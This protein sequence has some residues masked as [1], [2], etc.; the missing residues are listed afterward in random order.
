MLVPELPQSTTPS[1][2][3]NAS[4]PAAVDDDRAVVDRDV[5]TPSCASAARVRPTSSPPARPVTRDA[6]VGHRREQQRAVRHPLVAGHAQPSAQRARPGQD[7][8]VGLVHARA[9]ASGVRATW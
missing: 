9:H 1:G 8:L 4:T 5:A 3:A 2:S 7:Q 6:P